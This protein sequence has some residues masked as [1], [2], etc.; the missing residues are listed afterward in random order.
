MKSTL[1]K[2]LSYIVKINL[3]SFNIFNISVIMSIKKRKKRS[4]YKIYLKNIIQ[5]LYEIA[6]KKKKPLRIKYMKNSPEMTSVTWQSK[7]PSS[8]PSFL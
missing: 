8:I 4:L 5:K 3:F 1:R 2:R 7:D 6:S